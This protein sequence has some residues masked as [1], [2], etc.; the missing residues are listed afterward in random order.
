M[1]NIF[2]SQSGEL[3]KLKIIPYKDDEF[4][5]KGTPSEF[6]VLTNPEKYNIAYKAEQNEKDAIGTTGGN[7][8]YILSKS[9]K[10]VLD[11]LFD[12]TG[13]IDDSDKP[14]IDQIDDFK[15]VVFN[16]VGGIHRP[17]KLQII[18]GSLF[19]EGTLVDL[20]IEFTLFKPN[21]EPIRA[22]IKA[23]FTGSIEENLR[24]ALNKTSSPDLSHVRTVK[25][26]DTL[27]IMAKRIYGDAKYYLEVAKVN[28][29][30]NFRTL[31]PGQEIFFPPIEKTS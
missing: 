23:E 30:V 29:I 10:L 20:N 19:F 12:G 27:P 5:E 6:K 13:I 1:K 14:V 3:K 18:W 31:T 24:E 21:G 28:N 8:K 16:Y 17:H 26:G 7:S 9:P 2:K 15:K 22:I 4:K 25:A 11:F